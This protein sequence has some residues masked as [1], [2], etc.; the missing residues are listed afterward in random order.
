M[1]ALSGFPGVH[2]FGAYYVCLASL[3]PMGERANIKCSHFFGFLSS[4]G[5][6]TAPLVAACEVVPPWR[7]ESR[8]QRSTEEAGR[9]QTLRTQWLEYLRGGGVST[10]MSRRWTHKCPATA[11][12]TDEGMGQRH[13]G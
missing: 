6:Q 9:V 13:V 7:E 8:R 5:K 1:P 3:G 10:W 4:K 11:K 12:A 2:H